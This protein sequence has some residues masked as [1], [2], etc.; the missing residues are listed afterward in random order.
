[1]GLEFMRASSVSSKESI[2]AAMTLARRARVSRGGQTYEE[3]SALL[4]V[5]IGSPFGCL[6]RAETGV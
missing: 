6:G 1:V 4:Y 3:A 5:E 2:Q